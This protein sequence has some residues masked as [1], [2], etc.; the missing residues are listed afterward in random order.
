[1]SSLP[2]DS[3]DPHALTDL[4]NVQLI[5]ILMYDVRR[6]AIICTYLFILT[7]ILY[8]YDCGIIIFVFYFLIRIIFNVICA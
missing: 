1:M 2:A 5:G 3:C 6:F 7:V 4:A 8:Y